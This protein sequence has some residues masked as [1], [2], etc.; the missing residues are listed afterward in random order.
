MFRLL[1]VIIRQF[2]TYGLLSYSIHGDRYRQI[3]NSFPDVKYRNLQN[4]TVHV[5][6]IWFWLPAVLLPMQQECKILKTTFFCMVHSQKLILLQKH[7]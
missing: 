1:R 7:I 6:F 5:A 2:T 4:F 3:V